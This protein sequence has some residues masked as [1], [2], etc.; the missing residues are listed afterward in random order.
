MDLRLVAGHR[1]DAAV[2]AERDG[3][4]RRGADADYLFLIDHAGAGAEIS[5]DGIELLT[6]KPV[7]GSVTVPAGG[8]AVVREPH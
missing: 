8:V 6:G 2:G 7:C 3:P 5:A 1:E 4:E